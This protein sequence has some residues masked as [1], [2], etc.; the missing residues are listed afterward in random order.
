MKTRCG[1]EDCDCSHTIEQLVKALKAV[2][3]LMEQG[4]DYCLVCLRD[5]CAGHATDCIVGVAL[6]EAS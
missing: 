2:E 5:M 3:W 6:M 1:L 4:E